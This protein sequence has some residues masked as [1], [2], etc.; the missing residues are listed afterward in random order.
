MAK[1][2]LLRGN[3]ILVVTINTAVHVEFILE[4]R[5]TSSLD[6]YPQVAV[7]IGSDFFQSLHAAVTDFNSARITRC[8]SN[9]SSEVKTAQFLG[10]Q[11]TG[12]TI[13]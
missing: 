12:K 11:Q 4:S 6:S 2:A 7:V 8:R 1:S 9:F 10:R 5:A 3:F 13:F